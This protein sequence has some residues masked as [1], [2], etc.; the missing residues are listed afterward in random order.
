M[1]VTSHQVIYTLAHKLVCALIGIVL[2]VKGKGRVAGEILK[3]LPG[4]FVLR[5]SAH[6]IPDCATH[7]EPI[8]TPFCQGQRFGT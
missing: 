5:S 1:R 6:P 2:A 8:G 7:T 4:L 3:R